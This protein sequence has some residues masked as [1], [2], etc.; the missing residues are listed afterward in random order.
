MQAEP[1]LNITN[2]YTVVF[3]FLTVIT[4]NL[5]IFIVILVQA[6]NGLIIRDIPGEWFVKVSQVRYSYDNKIYI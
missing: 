5:E 3:F 2:R 4:Y 6:V 1:S